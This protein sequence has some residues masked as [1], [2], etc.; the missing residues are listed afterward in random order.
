M[1]RDGHGAWVN[2]RALE[3]AGL[4]A[5]TPDPPDGRIERDGDGTPTGTLHEGAVAL[6][7]R[8]APVD[9]LADQVQALLA[10]QAH[11]H[12]LGITAWQDAILGDFAGFPDASPAYTEVVASGRLTARVVGA[13]WW[14]RRRGLEQVDELV[15][16]R[17]RLSR[18]RFRAT[19]VKI[20]QDG[21]AENGTASMLEPYLDAHGVSTG[22]RGLSFVDPTVLGPAVTLL[23]AAGL[24]VHVHAIGDRA[25]RE[26]LDAVEVARTANGWSDARHHVAHLQLV[27]PH[28]IP[29]FRQLGVTAT[30]QPL[31]AA[32]D[33]QMR[34]LTL[35]FLG[36][37]RAS[38]Q[39]PFG[40]L[41]RAGAVLAAGSD[42]PVSSPDPMWGVHVAVNRVPPPDLQ[43]GASGEPFLPRQALDLASALTAYTAG[44]ARVNH[45]D[46]T[47]TIAVG[48]R[49]DLALLDRDPFAGPP[50][51][52]A[53]AR[54][55]RTWVGGDL[56]HAVDM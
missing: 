44:S 10:A 46:D 31:W 3:V 22:R 14:D 51:E 47:G 36:Q 54:V 13:L 50:E 52:I 23:D 39:Y 6:V 24:Q 38:W 48:Q 12:A 32:N 20:M 21:V 43:D 53:A 28:D 34:D 18:G 27:H 40:D 9:T 11:L 8:H 1:N 25:V 4:D 26:A 2:T 19:S 37:P 15:A 16:T 45:L 29:R 56:V 49:A 42:W 5:R 17:E 7:S 35:P 41:L 55:L 33:A 30:M